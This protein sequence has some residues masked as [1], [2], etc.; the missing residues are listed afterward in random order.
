MRRRSPY[1]RSRLNTDKTVRTKDGLRVLGKLKLYS[2]YQELRVLTN[3]LNVA[4][5]Q[6]RLPANPCSAVEF[7]ASISKSIRKPHY[8]TSSEQ[9]RIEIVAPDYLK[10]PLIILSEMGLRPTRNCSQLRS[11]K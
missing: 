6:K 5:R 3:I 1:L 8:M 7:P 2:V 9:A 11:H 10:N 4:V